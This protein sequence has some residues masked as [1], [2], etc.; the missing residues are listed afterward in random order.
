MDKPAANIDGCFDAHRR[1]EQVATTLVPSQL[2]EDSA[3]DGWT[4]G[5]VLAHLVL[6]AEAMTRRIEAALQGELIEQYAGGADG[7]SAAIDELSHLALQHLLPRVSGSAR[8]LDATFNLI[9]MHARSLPVRTVSGATHPI[10]L[11]PFRR[12][13]EVEVHLGDLDVGVGPTAWSNEFVNLVLRRLIA[14]MA[15]RADPRDLAAWLIGRAKPP[16]LTPWV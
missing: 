2:G 6:N 12:W 14:R 3:L 5:H 4:R 9:P 7:R 13:R 1:L 16:E 8:K 10:A 15:D 11:L